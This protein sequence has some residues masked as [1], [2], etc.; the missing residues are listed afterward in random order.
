M[1]KLI[2]A[3]LVLLP[4][5]VSGCFPGL[6]PVPEPEPEPEPTPE[7]V[8][9]APHAYID[10]VTPAPAVA[11]DMVSFEGHGTDTNGTVAAYR[12]RS[13]IDGELGDQASFTTGE[14]SAGD[15][16]IYFRVQDD[17]D[18]W[19]A[20]TEFDLTVTAPTVPLVIYDFSIAPEEIEAGETAILSWDVL[21]AFDIF[22]EPD[23][24]AV[25]TT[26]YQE[27][28]PTETT[29]YTL[30]ATAGDDEA[31]ATV[32]VTVTEPEELEILYFEADPQL[33]LSGEFSTLSWETTGATD[34]SI[35]QGV[36]EVPPEGSV[37][38]SFLGEQV[39]TYTLTATNGDETVTASI[40]VQSYLLMV[41]PDSYEVTL[42]AV[43]DESGYVRSTG[44]VTP[45]WIYVGD[46]T[47]NIPLQGFI[48]FD[49]SYLPSDAMISSVILDMSDY[50]SFLGV[51]LDL[52]C[53][54]I[55]VDD[56]GTLDSSDYFT[57]TPLGAIVRYCSLGEIV[58][59]ENDYLEDALQDRVGEDRLQ[60]RLQFRYTPTDGDSHNDIARWTA[61]HPPTITVSYY[62]YE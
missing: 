43:I 57:D 21:G 27:I 11:G 1:K 48:T 46:D 53:L 54:R 5:V 52:D 20:E 6:S 13:S 59:E 56:Y 51:P 8:N 16:A 12:W 62:S 17:D 32:E 30:T 22:I 26:G 40:D 15:H 29:V 50:D 2:I 19:S 9:Q 55:Y 49:I 39:K 3:L 38:V 4:L 60:L 45:K 18:E 36:G 44:Q 34:V 47:N 35:D 41:M 31:T 24:G 28:A 42:S 14:L 10:E 7:A 25:T 37:D 61:T 33:F 23:V 58:A